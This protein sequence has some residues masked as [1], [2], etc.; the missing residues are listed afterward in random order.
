MV[1]MLTFGVYWWYMLAYIPYM[2]PMV[3][4]TKFLLGTF[5]R[6]GRPLHCRGTPARGP[7]RRH[8]GAWRP[9][10]PRRRRHDAGRFFGRG[11]AGSA[12]LESE[13]NWEILIHH[14]YPKMMMKLAKFWFNQQNISAY[15]D[16]DVVY[17]FCWWMSLG[18]TRP[19]IGCIGDTTKLDMVTYG[20]KTQVI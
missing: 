14:R 1:Y 3:F 9:A 20:T 8:R 10:A 13:P 4:D 6:R 12:A 2:D 19:T 11:A 16:L 15:W 18:Y 17:G 7:R 5:L